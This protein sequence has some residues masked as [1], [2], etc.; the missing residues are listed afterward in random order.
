MSGGHSTYT[1]QTG[2]GRWMGTRLPV[3]RLVYVLHCLS[4]PR[5]LNYAYTFSGILALMLVVSF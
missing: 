3:P 1:P 4:V 5:N 2:L